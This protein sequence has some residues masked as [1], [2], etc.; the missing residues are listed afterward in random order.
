[1]DKFILV[2]TT[3]FEGG[4]EGDTRL[5]GPMEWDEANRLEDDR[6]RVQ[7]IL[8]ENDGD[9]ILEDAK[10]AYLT[11]PNLKH[12]ETEGATNASLL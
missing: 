9:L 6:D 10:V 11:C 1:M 7:A 5:L 2:C 3:T 8:D 4:S 12:I